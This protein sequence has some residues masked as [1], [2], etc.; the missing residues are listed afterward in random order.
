[1]DVDITPV[2]D[3]TNVQ[4]Q[5]YT[6]LADKRTPAT[7]ECFDARKMKLRDVL[8]KWSDAASTELVYK[9]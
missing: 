5:A 7:V 6:M 4:R 1:M 2:S 9:T 3:T 8:T